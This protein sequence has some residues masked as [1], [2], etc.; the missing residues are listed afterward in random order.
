MDCFDFINDW[1]FGMVLNNV[2][3]VFGDRIER[4]VVKV[5]MYNVDWKMDYFVSWNMGIVIGWM[6]YVF[7]W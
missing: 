3:F 6:W 7:V 5:V 1:I 2:F 4:V